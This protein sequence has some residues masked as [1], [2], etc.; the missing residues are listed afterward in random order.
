MRSRGGRS[1][2]GRATA[3]LES[4]GRAELVGGCRG[5]GGDVNAPIVVVTALVADARATLGFGELA[6]VPLTRAPRGHVSGDRRWPREVSAATGDE[7]REEESASNPVG[8]PGT[9]LGHARL[10]GAEGRR[11]AQHDAPRKAR[12]VP[13]HGEVRSR[14]EDAS[15]SGLST[16]RRMG[17]GPTGHG[18]AATEVE[19]LTRAARSVR[20][21]TGT[22]RHGGRAADS[23]C[24][25]G[26]DAGANGA[27][28]G[29]PRALAFR[30]HE[31][32]RGTADPNG[33]DGIG[34]GRPASI[35]ASASSAARS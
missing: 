13:T 10:G 18:R 6:R 29:A 32:G 16:L 21:C 34:T 15:R 1:A 24:A 12:A 30:G 20:P 19:R 5:R 27:D 11:D 28:G 4:R 26:V 9:G 22:G 31:Q 3:P 23:C 14:R 2:G 35:A 7:E 17:M 25:N 33:Q 8:Q